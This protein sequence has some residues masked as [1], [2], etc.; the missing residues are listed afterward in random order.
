[1]KCFR[2][3]G[4]RLTGKTDL[5]EELEDFWNINKNKAFSV[6]PNTKNVP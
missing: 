1:V 5:Q 2:N 4:K 6:P 3:T